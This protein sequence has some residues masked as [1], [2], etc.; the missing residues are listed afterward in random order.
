MNN[1]FLDKVIYQIISE[2]RVKDDLLHTP[3]LPRPSHLFYL[4]DFPS[5]SSFSF[6]FFISHCKKV[7]SLNEQ[8]ID[9]VWV[10]Y[11]EGLTTLMED[12]EPSHQE[13]G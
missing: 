8:E 9:Y 7:Y 10:K 4:P 6:P 5:F 1:K 3:F 12:M 2:T 13:K 11:K